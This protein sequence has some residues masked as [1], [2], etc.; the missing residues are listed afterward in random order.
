MLGVAI[1]IARRMG[2]HSESALARCTI[3]EAEMR[4]RLWWSLILFDTRINEV[5]ASKTT[6]LDPTWD[7]KVP[8]NVNDSDLRPEMKGPPA[9]QGNPSEALFAVVRSELGEFIRHSVFHLD[10]NSPALKPIAKSLQN[11]PSPETDGVVKLEELIE[12]QYLKFCDPENP[13]HFMTIWT[14]RASL[15]KCHLMEYHSRQSSSSVSPTEA[16]RDT[17]TSHAL[18]MLE[19]DTKIMTS[20]L[21]KGYL[22]LNHLYFP[23]P[24]YIQIVQDLRRRPISERVQQ[25][26]DVMSDN[27]AAWF[28]AQ[29][30]DSS[31]F[32]RLLC[33]LVLHA[34]EDCEAASKQKGE[35]LTTPRIV[36][37]IRDRLDQ[38][39]P[40]AGNT[41]IEQRDIIAGLG[42]DELPMPISIDFATQNLAYSMGMQ[43][44]YAAMRS[45][46][47]AGIPGQAPLDADMDQWDWA[48]LSGSSGWGG[49]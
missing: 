48:A 39:A 36:S 17:A 4:R 12:K 14:T 37:T 29:P 6:T 41:D 24:A 25:A 9:T 38:T 11:G 43:D 30:K 18:R 42:M 1:R 5:A 19:C 26:W 21:T 34:W 49:G 35:A 3:A 16:Q 45:E 23:F 32:F 47:Y 10:F 44:G 22:W 28:D 40:R 46:I 33:K 8:L 2:I 20:P 15:A 7:C 31:P 27:H 13:I